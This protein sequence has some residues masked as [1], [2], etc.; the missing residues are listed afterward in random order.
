MRANSLKDINCN[1]RKE[2][3]D[4]L[5]LFYN[6]IINS[7][8]NAFLELSGLEKEQVFYR[9]LYGIHL[10]VSQFYSL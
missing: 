9:G 7:L 10:D 1:L 8:D 5:S 4:Y 2:K 3:S 6:K